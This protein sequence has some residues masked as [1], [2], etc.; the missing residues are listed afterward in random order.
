MV[1]AVIV[2][3]LVVSLL[4]LVIV[5][6]MGTGAAG[7]AG[8]AGA[9]GAAGA[10]VVVLLRR[11]LSALFSTRQGAFFQPC[12]SFSVVL[13]PSL[14]QMNGSASRDTSCWSRR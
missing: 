12:S 11:G 4:V 1:L 3:L 14:L 10:A 2:L 8:D 9:A 5:M 6:V 7:A 13:L